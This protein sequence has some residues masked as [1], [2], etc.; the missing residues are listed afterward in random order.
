MHVVLTT[1]ANTVKR[2]FHDRRPVIWERDKLPSSLY[3][4]WPVS[5]VPSG[6]NGREQLERS[7]PRTD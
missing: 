7:S 1:E 6:L 3:R 2:P 4:D 5:A